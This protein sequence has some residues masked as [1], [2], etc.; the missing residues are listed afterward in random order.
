MRLIV[1][2]GN[3]GRRYRGSRHNI[4]ARVIEVLARRHGVTLREEGWADVGALTLDRVHV[5]LAR[6]QTY[7]NVSGLAVADLR[8]RHRVP[9]PH[10]LVVY[11]DLDLPLGQIRLRA[12]GGHGGHN[13]MRSIIEALGEQGFPRL[14]LGIGRPPA[15]VDPADYVLS[16]FD[17]AEAP[18]VDAAVERA[19]DAVE[20]FVQEGIE[21]AMSAFNVRGAPA[22]TLHSLPSGGAGDA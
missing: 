15:G 21:R 17:R 9:L 4:G 3:P 18:L 20:M 5:L 11:D 7:V 22:R 6:P 10:L 12:G 8:R 16:R 19:A 14:R 13:G 1:G 2:L